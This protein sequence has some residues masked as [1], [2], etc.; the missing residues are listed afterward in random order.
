MCA[1]VRSACVRP[2]TLT[3]VAIDAQTAAVAEN[4]RPELRPVV[5]VATDVRA[6][7]SSDA[8]KCSITRRI[9]DTMASVGKATLRT[10]RKNKS[11]RGGADLDGDDT[12]VWGDASDKRGASG[13]PLLDSANQDPARTLS[14]RVAKAKSHYAGSRYYKRKALPPPPPPLVH[15]KRLL[16]TVRQAAKSEVC[17]RSVGVGVGVA[18]GV[19]VGAG[20]QDVVPWVQCLTHMCRWFAFVCRAV[21]RVSQ[22]VFVCCAKRFMPQCQA[23]EH[24]FA[25]ILVSCAIVMVGAVCCVVCPAGDVPAARSCPAFLLLSCIPLLCCGALLCADLCARAGMCPVFPLAARMAH[26]PYSG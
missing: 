16:R 1:L 11:F 20:G 22:L 8:M 12:L 7:V 19:G 25:E 23:V 15:A 4:V 24:I 9:N 14:R 26:R 13:N 10:T 18:V 3:L 2:Q 5:S 17:S 21:C 6:R